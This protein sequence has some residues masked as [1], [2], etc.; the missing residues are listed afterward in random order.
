[1]PD[2]VTNRWRQRRPLVPMV[3][4]V[5][6]R[7]LFGR[8]SFRHRERLSADDDKTLRHRRINYQTPETA[9]KKKTPPHFGGKTS[10]L[11]LW[12]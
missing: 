9:V 11:A 8:G 5:E 1:M 4:R 3:Y 10:Q 6:D 7:Q 2:D 12:V